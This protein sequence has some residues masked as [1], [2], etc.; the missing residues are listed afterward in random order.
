ME[1]WKRHQTWANP[2]TYWGI[3]YGADINGLGA[4]GDPRPGAAKTTR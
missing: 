3:G 1:K 4:Q 2:G